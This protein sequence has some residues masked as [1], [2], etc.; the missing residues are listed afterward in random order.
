M[1]GIRSR[2]QF[3]GSTDMSIRVCFIFCY[4]IP[5]LHSFIFGISITHGYWLTWFIFSHSFIHLFFHSFIHACFLFSAFVRP[6]YRFLWSYLSSV[7]LFIHSFNQ[8]FSVPV[9]FHS[10]VRSHPP[11]P[12][13]N[14]S[15]LSPQLFDECMAPNTMGDGTGCDNMTCIIVRFLPSLAGVTAPVATEESSADAAEG[16]CSGAPRP[17]AEGA[18]P[19]KRQRTE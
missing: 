3:W 1:L 6:L 7:L 11:H 10:F 18:P 14:T 15:P 4:F 9:S 5:A 8:S 17:E 13:C 16:D 12:P 2:D 19:E